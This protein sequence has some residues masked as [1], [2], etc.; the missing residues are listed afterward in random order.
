[1]VDLA[2]TMQPRPSPTPP[3]N[4]RRSQRATWGS[5]AGLSLLVVVLL[6]GATV[7][8]DA[9]GTAATS[10]RGP[11]AV[12]EGAGSPPPILSFTAVPNPAEVGVASELSVT[13]LGNITLGDEFSYSGLPGG[14]A[15]E[16][17]SNLTCTP[18][19][20]GTFEVTVSVTSILGTVEK[21]LNWTV[22]AALAVTIAAAAT[23]VPLSVRFAGTVEG[24]VA[25]EQVRWNFGD[26]ATATDSLFANHTFASAGTYTVTLEVV[27]ALAVAATSVDN[28]TLSLP[29]GTLIAVAVD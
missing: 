17:L 24:G 26:G 6:L 18:T 12:I 1:M 10:A 8:V 27:D 13:I 4:D 2:R 21:S 5:A 22:E 16:S 28:L 29:T 25:L 15:S 20:S 14:C 3:P 19:N 23:S 7:L 9:A 11:S